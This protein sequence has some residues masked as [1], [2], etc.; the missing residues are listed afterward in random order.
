M[1]SKIN[2]INQSLVDSMVIDAAL[3]RKDHD[4]IPCNYDRRGL[5]EP[6]K[7]PNQ[8]KLVVKIRKN[9]TIKVKTDI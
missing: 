7:S 6:L 9:K 2:K 1:Y 8:I 5:E 4:S 3:G